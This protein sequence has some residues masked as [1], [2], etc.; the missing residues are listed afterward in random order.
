MTSSIDATFTTQGHIDMMCDRFVKLLKADTSLNGW[1]GGRIMRTGA[2]SAPHGLTPPFMLV[3]ALDMQPTLL[4]G[5]IEELVVPIGIL[6]VWEDLRESIPEGGRSIATVVQKIRS[7]LYADPHLTEGSD[8]AAERINGIL[9]TG[10]EGSDTD[11]DKVTVF[12]EIRAEY[13]VRVQILTQESY[14]C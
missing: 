2:F 12:A 1:T 6:L 4:P 11:D 7:V 13:R 3:T 9:V 5:K 10:L 14:R 8:Y